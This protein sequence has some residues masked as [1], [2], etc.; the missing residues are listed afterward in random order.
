MFV[1]QLLGIITA[2]VIVVV[3]LTFFVTFTWDELAKLVAGKV[4]KQN[5]RQLVALERE[6]A[7]LRRRIDELEK[8]H[9][10]RA[11]F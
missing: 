7:A 5:K 1:F 3:I 10:A 8:S 2:F 9:V 11:T 6:N 4:D